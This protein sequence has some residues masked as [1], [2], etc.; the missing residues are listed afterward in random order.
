[1]KLR[2]IMAGVVAS[3]IAVSALAVSTF[4]Y[5]DDTDFKAGNTDAGLNI[6]GNNWLIQLYNTGNPDENKPAVDYGIDLSKVTGVRVTWHV[7]DDGMSREAWDGS[8]GG[9]LVFSVNGG[10]IGSS[11]DLYNKYNWPGTADFWGVTDE[12]LGIDTTAPEKALT[13]KTLG[14]YTYSVEMNNVL[15]NP[16][17]EDGVKEVGCFQICLQE[18]GSALVA[19]HVDKMEVL[20]TDGNVLIAFDELGKKIEDGAAAE[21]PEEPAQSE[22]PAESEAPTTGD[23]SKPSTNTGAE[24]IAVAA[25]VAVL[26]AG[27]AVIAKKRK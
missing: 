5:P 4:A 11:G 2:K 27:A 8:V 17:V 23:S 7:A 3:A 9:A 22:T 26:A 20:D 21:E 14:D 18:W 13:T 10:D 25:G 6:S 12:E 24:G 1:M 19:Q 15:P 16:F